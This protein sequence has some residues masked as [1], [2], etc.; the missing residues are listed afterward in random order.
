MLDGPGSQI[1]IQKGDYVELNTI[2]SVTERHFHVASVD[3]DGS[4]VLDLSSITSRS[5]IPS[6]TIRL[7]P[8]TRAD[9]AAPPKD[10][11][12]S[13]NASAGTAGSG[14]THGE[15]CSPLDGIAAGIRPTIRTSW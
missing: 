9:H 7:S 4:A 8:T 6:T 1:R 12:T 13:R 5:P 11:K 14:S 3:A 10:L 2:Q 15:S